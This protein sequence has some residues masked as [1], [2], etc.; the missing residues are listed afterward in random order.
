MARIIGLPF[1]GFMVRLYGA[2]L[3]LYV[4]ITAYQFIRAA[5]APIAATLA[6][7]N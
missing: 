6:A 5:F 4:G 2:G 3:A 1:S 7:V